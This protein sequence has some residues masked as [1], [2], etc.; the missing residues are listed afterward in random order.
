MALL[1]SEFAITPRMVLII[2]NCVKVYRPGRFNRIA[3]C[4]MRVRA[5]IEY[6]TLE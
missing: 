3:T 4:N 5:K 1:A 6:F 2:V